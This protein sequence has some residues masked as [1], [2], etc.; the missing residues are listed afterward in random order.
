MNEK[1]QIAILILA[2]GE[3]RR[4][5]EKVKQLLPWGGSTLLGHA[6][7]NAKDSSAAKVYVVLGAHC[8]LITKQVSVPQ[9]QI[10]LNSNWKNGLGSSIAAGI[11]HF[12]NKDKSYDAVLIMLADQP[13]IDDSYIN[14]MITQWVGNTSQIVTT[15]YKNKKGVPAIFGASYF[16]ELKKLGGDFGA[17][18]IILRHNKSVST[19]DP[20]GKATDVDTFKAYQRLLSESGQK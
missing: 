13:M 4:M 6:Y 20:Q 8:D 10:I 3:S 12:T 18:D 17:K 14:E 9:Q 7:K 5:G 1:P 2:A 11:K 16:L 19:L 15:Q